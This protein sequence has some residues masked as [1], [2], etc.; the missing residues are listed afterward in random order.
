MTITIT[1]PSYEVPIVDDVDVLVVGGGVAGIAAAVCASRGKAKTLLVERYAYLGGLVTGAMVLQMNDMCNE[2]EIVIA[3]IVDELQ[4]RLEKLGGLIKPESP[5]WFQSSEKLYKEWYWW[6]VLEKY[7]AQFP[8]RVIYRPIIDVESTKFACQQMLTESGVKVR[9][10]STFTK[11]LVENN[12]CVGAIFFSKS[13]YYAI[14]AKIVIDATGDGDVFASA[15]ADY[16]KGIYLITTSHYIGNVDT[17]TLRL[18]AEEYPNKFDEISEEVR[19][20]YGLSWRQWMFFTPDRSV[21]WCDCPHFIKKDGLNIEHL[22][23]IEF[24]GRRRIWKALEYVK[25]NLPGFKNAYISKVGDQTGVR[26]SRL[27][28][29]EYVLTMRDINLKTR[30][31]DSIGRGGKY[32]YPYRSLVPKTNDG[33]LVAGRHFSVKPHAQVYARE[34]PPC[35]VTGQAAGT[36]AAL[37]LACNIEVREIDI[38]Q[39]QRKLIEQGAIL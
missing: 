13:G 6:G 17:E 5:D 16:E 11:A 3:G 2:N 28:I 7:G 24:E 31:K 4:N 8:D 10:H 36:A 30:F 32:T 33:L 39:L 23:E 22:T 35:M 20:I 38:N 1:V 29:G 25:G 15:G 21:V 19:K 9:L 26:Q 37:A 18:F 27:L 34:W 14:K 12:K